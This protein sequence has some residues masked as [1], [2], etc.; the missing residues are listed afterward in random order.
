[1]AGRSLR[2][3]CGLGGEADAKQN[4]KIREVR[5]GLA[6]GVGIR[7]AFLL[8]YAVCPH[9][10]MRPRSDLPLNLGEAELGRSREA[11]SGDRVLRW[12]QNAGA[13]R[14]MHGW[15]VIWLPWTFCENMDTV[16][17]ADSPFL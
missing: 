6:F 12:C 13:L 7:A 11:Q 8:D 15:P 14:W 3:H 16:L 17:C 1:M 5:C 10:A 4:T 2:V 9:N